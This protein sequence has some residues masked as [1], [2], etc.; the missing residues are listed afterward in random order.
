MHNG[1]RIET[2]PS[3]QIQLLA[4][5]SGSLA[6]AVVVWCGWWVVAGAARLHELGFSDGMAGASQPRE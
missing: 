5:L 2:Q 1:I 3:K 6:A 4:P